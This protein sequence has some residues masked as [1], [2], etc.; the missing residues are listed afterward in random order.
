MDRASWRP[1][2]IFGLLAGWGG[3]ARPESERV[4]NM[5]VGMV[6]VVA[7]ADADLALAL[8][9]DR[10]LPAWIIGR[11]TAGTGTARLTG[12]HPT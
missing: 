9:A 11:V 4:F 10:D 5:G 1:A 2:P 3:V 7:A 6:A 8:L 12:E